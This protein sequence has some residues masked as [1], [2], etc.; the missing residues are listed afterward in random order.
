M[1]KPAI[2]QLILGVVG[3]SLIIFLFLQPKFIVE[4]STELLNDTSSV[5]QSSSMQ[6]SG[7]NDVYLEEK[8]LAKELTVKLNSFSN[9]EEKIIFA[10]SLGELYFD[11]LEYDSSAKYF[12]YVVSLENKDVNLFKAGLANYEAFRSAQIGKVK[13]DYAM[14]AKSYFND[15]LEQHPDEESVLVKKAVLMVNTE[16]PPMGGINLL[17]NIIQK[18]PSNV[19]ALE[20]LGEFQFTI[21]KYKKAIGSFE[22][23]VELNNKNDKALLYLIWSY[24]S[25]GDTESARLYLNKIKELEISDVYIKSLIDKEAA[26]LN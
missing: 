2:F 20:S 24:K 11:I 12:D 18:N 17:K 21:G 1:K 26:E 3:L 15:Y 19:E 16:R 14:R 25:L 7:H 9:S 5:V 23:V 22:R 8:Q 4:D 10:D 13:Q 6:E